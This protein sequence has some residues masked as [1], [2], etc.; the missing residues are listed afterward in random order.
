MTIQSSCWS[1]T[2]TAT[3]KRIGA[4]SFRQLPTRYQ[5]RFAFLLGQKGRF[6]TL[7]TM[8]PWAGREHE[9][10]G[11]E[12]FGLTRRRR[13]RKPKSGPLTGARAAQKP[14]CASNM[15]GVCELAGLEQRTP[16]GD[17]NVVAGG[18]AG[19]DEGVRPTAE[20]RRAH[21]VSNPELR[22]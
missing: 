5:A 22:K 15:S 16:L 19:P 20:A 6:D 1:A 10:Q 3:I 14:D 18:N 11:G 21:Q 13:G 8:R 4:A 12:G 2:T 7:G 9:I 17:A